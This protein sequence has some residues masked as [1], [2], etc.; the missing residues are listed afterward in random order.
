MTYP[1]TSSITPALTDE[2]TLEI[3][4]TCLTEH[5]FFET[6]GE[7]SPSDLFAV[8]LHSASRGDSIEHT[9]KR[10]NGVTML[11]TPSAIT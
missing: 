8:M 6:E 4:S 2:R 3:A 11:A 1:N 10:L 9:V 5:L 7:Y